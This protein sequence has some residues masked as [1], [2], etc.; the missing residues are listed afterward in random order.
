[1]LD[2]TLFEN[3]L[4]PDPN[5]YSAQPVNVRSHDLPAIVQRISARYPG[6]SPTQILAAISEFFDEVYNITELGE[7]VVTPIFNTEFS[8][9]GV[10]NGALDSFDTKR[11]SVKIN[12]NPGTRLLEAARKVKTSKVIV[13]ESLPHILEVKDVVSNTVNELLTPGGIV[14]IRG[15][16]LKFLQTEDNN[17][18]FFINQ[19]G[20]SIKL[21]VIADNKPARIMAMLPADMQPGTYSL[22]VRTSFSAGSVKPLHALKTGRFNKELTVAGNNE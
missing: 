12:L 3:M 10:Y 6:L 21:S 7:T 19:Q 1:M 18:V 17:G 20:E 8:M 11:H 15:S 9:P 4:T 2:Y 14:Q 13:A 5:D 16:R 22:E